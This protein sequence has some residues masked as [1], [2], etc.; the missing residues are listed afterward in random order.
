MSGRRRR[1]TETPLHPDTRDYA[2]RVAAN[3]G[4]V[5]TADLRAIDTILV[6]PAYAL[7]IRQQILRKNIFLGSSL[8]EAAVSLWFPPSESD[9]ITLINVISGNYSRTG[10]L[11]FN[12]TNSYTNCITVPSNYLNNAT[13]YLS[14]YSLTNN[15]NSL[16]IVDLSARSAAGSDFNLF[17]GFNVDAFDCFSS[18]GSRVLAAETRTDGW[19]VGSRVSTVDSRRYRNGTQSGFQS[20][21]N[22]T[23][24]PGVPGFLGAYNNNNTPQFFSNRAYSDF[25]IGYGLTPAQVANWYAQIQLFQQY[26]G[27]AVIG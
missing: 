10:G 15:S 27:R 18:S 11:Q 16:S 8:A 6:R 13:G 1:R 21:A 20:N 7:G 9:K 26:M 25:E 22:T 4:S 14:Y 2:A 23:N 12:G 24:P 17:S 19:I 5:S 3:G